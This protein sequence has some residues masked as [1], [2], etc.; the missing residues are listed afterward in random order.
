MKIKMVI[1]I[2]DDRKMSIIHY[3]IKIVKKLNSDNTFTIPV[4]KIVFN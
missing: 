4:K 1:V 3:I 2:F